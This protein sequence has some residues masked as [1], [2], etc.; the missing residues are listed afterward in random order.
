M[1]RFEKSADEFRSSIDG[2]APAQEAGIP[3]DVPVDL[4]VLQGIS[5]Y[6]DR[7]TGDRYGEV[8]P[9][10]LAY[11]I[12]EVLTLEEQIPLYHGRSF[13]YPVVSGVGLDQGQSVAD[14]TLWSAAANIQLLTY[15]YGS[16]LFAAEDDTR[17]MRAETWVAQLDDDFSVRIQG[18]SPAS[19]VSLTVNLVQGTG[20][21][22]TPVSRPL[23]IDSEFSHDDMLGARL[24]PS[25]IK[26]PA[27]GHE[28]ALMFA[29]R[30]G[31]KPERLLG[32]VS[33]HAMRHMQPEY[34]LLAPD[35]LPGKDRVY[36]SPT[37][38]VGDTLALPAAWH[39]LP[40]FEQDFQE[41]SATDD[42]ESALLQSAVAAVNTA[43]QIVPPDGMPGMTLPLYL[44]I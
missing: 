14:A 26:V 44:A 40:E 32:L 43:R 41:M 27:A 16:N 6:I 29:D 3:F 36:T 12:D 42:A 19:T 23:T 35:S 17:H 8:D 24:M 28:A 25:G 33:L 37:Y 20:E 4:L 1:M 34:G 39:Y 21:D 15:E 18:G 5:S 13:N 2:P 10:T 30:Y 11:F 9:A 38:P 7:M 22:S 31:C